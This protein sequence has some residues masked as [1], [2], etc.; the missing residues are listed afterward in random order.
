MIWLG[1]IS[2]NNFFFRKSV[3]LCLNFSDPLLRQNING[4]TFQNPVG[5]AAGFD[6]NAEM[7]EIAPYLGFGF[8]EVGSITGEPCAG[9]PKPRL[10]RLPKS[11]SI[12][13]NYG[14][15]NDGAQVIAQRL[16]PW[17]ASKI[18]VGINIAK[19]NSA[20]TDGIKNGINDYL[21]GIR[22]FSGIGDYLTINI[23]CPNTSGGQPFIEPGLLDKL[24]QEVKQL[25]LRKP[26]FLKMP[27]DL[28]LEQI[29]KIID[30]S[31]HY[32]LTGFI[33]SNLTKNRD[34]PLII[35]KEIS[36]VPD[37]VGGISGKPAEEMS[38]NQIAHIFKKTNGRKIIIGCGGIFSAQDA[39]KKIR[40]G[41]SLVQLIT[42][43]IFEGPQII[44][45]IN[46][47]LCSLLRK[48]RFKNISEA[49]GADIN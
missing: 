46:L 32:H 19:T 26:I 39:Y 36:Q 21:K 37:G 44:S 3:S 49:I 2:G 27:P 16:N 48:D 5:L 8:I 33:C 14:L 42:G 34:N 7:I 38:N 31:E 25:N 20:E 17:R 47:G 35:S 29:D 12:V 28:L 4:I 24:F 9:N 43:M 6:K 22:L 41:A 30:L 11:K 18:P 1:K 23:S 10:W 15:K 45:D 40:L 13:V